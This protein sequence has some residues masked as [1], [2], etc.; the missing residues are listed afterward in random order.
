MNERNTNVNTSAGKSVIILGGTSGVARYIARQFG[1]RGYTV[2]VAGRDRE[3]LDI[4]AA[5]VRARYAV[6]CSVL[7]FDATAFDTHGDFLDQCAQVFGEIPG[8]VVLCFGYMADQALAQKDFEVAR[9]TL[10]TN[11]TGAVSIL[12][13]FADAYEKRGYGFIAALTSVAGDRGRKMNY[14]YGASKAGLTTYLQGLR[15]RL[16]P[17]GIRV[18]TIKPGFMDTAMTYGMKLPR[19]LVAAPE[20][21]AKSM[22]DKI[23]RGKDMAYVPFFWR[24]IMWIIKN[25][26]EWQFKKMSV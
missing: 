13:R 3:E 16:H 21:A 12:E 2:G 9:R 5:D 19:P 14:I 24:Y 8:G 20:A 6:A 17:S 18:T 11:F 10:D 4:L 23:V 15:N 7:P 1:M 25:I 26:P 22:V